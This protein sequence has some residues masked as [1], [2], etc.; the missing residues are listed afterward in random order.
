MKRS[1]TK[2][3]LRT[4]IITVFGAI[5]GISLYHDF[6]AG[7]FTLPLAVLLFGVASVAGAFLSRIVPMQAHPAFGL[8]TLSFDRVYFSLIL[9][10]VVVKAVASRTGGWEPYAD[11][12]MCVIL[13]LML[14]RLSG[15]CLR[16]RA[17]KVRHG[18][19]PP[20]RPSPA[21]S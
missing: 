19:H 2:L 6:F 13:G 21:A 15:I 10:L 7:Y 20:R 11:A 9:A 5:F 17:L 4:L 3:W 14:G 16:V 18:I 8:I 12:V 1:R